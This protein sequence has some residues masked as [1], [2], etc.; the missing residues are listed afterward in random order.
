MNIVRRIK[1]ECS[2]IKCNL[3]E[4]AVI[5]RKWIKT[6]FPLPHTSQSRMIAGP[7]IWMVIYVIQSDTNE[8]P[9]CC[10]LWWF[11][12]DVIHWNKQQLTH[13]TYLNASGKYIVFTPSNCI[14]H[15]KNKCNFIV[16]QMRFNHK[17]HTKNAPQQAT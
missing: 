4:I 1:N 17:I 14:A 2:A 5:T 6:Y 12:V 16:V 9:C 7:F 10:T 15:A 8:Y 3:L 13:T 11:L